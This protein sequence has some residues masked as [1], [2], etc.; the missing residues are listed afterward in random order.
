[1]CLTGWGNDGQLAV[2][3]LLPK[4][5]E[6][7]REV[8]VVV[9]DS[10]AFHFRHD[11]EELAQRTRLLAA[12]AQSLTN[13]AKKYKVAVVLMNQVSVALHR[14][15]R[16]PQLF[17]FYLRRLPPRSTAVATLRAA[18]LKAYARGRA[19]GLRAPLCWSP[20][21][22]TAGVTPVPPAAC[23]TGITGIA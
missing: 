20:H 23:C 5:L 11:Y 8:R 9:V 7:H 13:I 1:M 18:A 6:E 15:A 22:A 2:N 19:G 14:P 17:S 10:V 21:W 16:G 4:F 12:Y 3:H